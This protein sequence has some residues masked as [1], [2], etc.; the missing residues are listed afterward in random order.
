MN[1]KDHILAALREEYDRWEELLASLQEAQINSTPLLPSH[2]TIKD[3]I[4][5]LRAWQQRSI[6]RVEAA[7]LN[8]APVFPWVPEDIDP[9]GE[10]ATDAINAWIYNTYREQPWPK[11]HQ[12]WSRGFQR[13]LDVA[14]QIP[15]RDL[16]DTG[17]YPWLNG[18][19]LEFILVAS[20][21]HH[22]EHLEKLQAWL[23]EHR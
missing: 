19:P 17:R 1:M 20:Y 18:Y 10:E 11:V 4:A 5:H 16:L 9:G 12:D 8:R 3:D 15:E 6:A 2:W 14:G 21:D 23:Q 7:Q 22:Q 13:F